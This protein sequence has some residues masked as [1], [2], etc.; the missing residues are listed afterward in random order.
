[1]LDMLFFFFKCNI[2]GEGQLLKV[3]LNIFIDQRI[4]RNAVLPEIFTVNIKNTAIIKGTIFRVT[5]HGDCDHEVTFTQ[6]TAKL[7]EKVHN[8]VLVDELYE[9][10]MKMKTSL[11]LND[12][13]FCEHEEQ[14]NDRTEDKLSH[15]AYLLALNELPN[16]SEI[17]KL[18]YTIILNKIQC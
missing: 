1:M 7:I 15:R 9:V 5:G 4:I 13:E 17:L 14:S 2:I 12:Q 11:S 16:N 10:G 18:N 3:D 6:F 8:D